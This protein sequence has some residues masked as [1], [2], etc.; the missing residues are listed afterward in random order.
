MK[1]KDIYLPF[2]SAAALITFTFL[3]PSPFSA[4]AAADPDAAD[5][6][7]VDADFAIQ[8]EYTG[9]VDGQKAG[10]QIV[11]LGDG[12]FE[13][14]LFPGGLPGDGWDGNRETLRKAPGKRNDDGSATFTKDGATAVVR[15]G[16]ITLSE[17]GEDGGNM[18]RVVRESPTLGAKAPEGAVILFDGGNLEAWQDGARMTD[19]KLL[20]EGA[21]TKDKFGSFTAH[22]EFRLP[23]QPKA[24]GQGRGNSGFYS[25]SRYEVQML[26]SFGLEGRDNE[27]GGIYTVASPSVNMCFPPLQWQTYDVEFTAAEFDA[28]GKKTK[29]AR[30]TVRHNGVVIHD[31]IEV[32][33]STTAAPLGEGPEPGP[34]HFQNHGNP[35]RYRNIWLVKK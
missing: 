11:A 18:E 2:L 23:Y 35:V 6:A 24:R 27:C 20:M 16:K 19:D 14:I 22:V 9:M 1:K 28:E 15:D 8:G 4:R 10:I 7:K 3:A 32:P 31:N 21:N 17:N 12:N 25:Q 26:D 34:L 33:K 30:L 5:P 13:G 29:N